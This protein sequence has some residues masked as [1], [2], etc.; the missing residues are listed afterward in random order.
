MRAESFDHL[1]RRVLPTIKRGSLSILDLGAGNGWLS[2]R[3][4]ALGHGCVAVD[5]L[6]DSD[7][8]LGAFVHYRTTF[9]CVQADF[10]FLPFAPAQFDLIVYNASVHYAPDVLAT[11]RHACQVLT[12]GGALAIMDSPTFRFAASGRQMLAEQE[13]RFRA[14]YGLSEIV[15]PGV[16]YLTMSAMAEAGERLG[17]RFRFLPSRGGAS[18]AFW[19]LVAGFK[20]GREPARFGL[21]VASREDE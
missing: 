9:A 14:R 6:D 15:R 13:E 16:G 18:W 8:G 7:D 21:W 11:L 3:L 20:R 1:C 17:L 10:D 12:P 4:A 5:W 2:H 19:R